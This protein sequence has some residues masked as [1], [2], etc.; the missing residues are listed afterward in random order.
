MT[1]TSSSQGEFFVID[2]GAWGRVTASGINS[3][4]AY[5]VLASGSGRNNTSTSW[6]THAVMKYAGVG[7]ERA[8]ASIAT[9]V[10]K[11]FVQ[12]AEGHTTERPRY[13]LTDSSKASATDGD[14]MMKLHPNDR[15]LL[16]KL[17][18]GW[19]PQNKTSHRRAERLLELGILRREAGGAYVRVTAPTV[20]S[21]A[22]PIWLPNTIVTGTSAGEETPTS[23]LRSAGCIWTL[24][25]FIDL[26]RAQNLRDDG[27]IDHRLLRQ[28]FE[29]R[30]I[31]QQGAYTMWGF[32]PGDL[33]L[34]LTGPLQPQ[35]DRVDGKPEVEHP[36]WGSL[37]L[38]RG[39]GLLSFVPHIFDNDGDAA[40]PIH[41]YGVGGSAEAPEEWK[42]G[43]AAAAA[44]LAMA[45][46]KKVEEAEKEGFEYFCPVLKTKPSAQMIG[47]A[48][49]AYR[50]HTR[51]TTSWFAQLL[52]GAPAWIE[53]YRALK[54]MGDR[55]L[56][57]RVKCRA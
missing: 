29:R 51:R 13:R 34:S 7:W 37:G 39:M 20:E 52:E 47:V 4:V 56:W 6:S 38:L 32:K 53:H 54:D 44:A 35:R 50:P 17:T 45:L 9:L 23:R 21:S 18:K 27:G 14:L 42:I 36:I 49:L 24:R 8:K 41:A 16:V 26:Y 31:G 40:E 25:L 2:S 30:L 22:E 12:Y 15:S 43:L 28:I 46:P 33:Q 5:L 10:A 1:R 57:E 3:A 11:G 19:Q 48:R 55:V